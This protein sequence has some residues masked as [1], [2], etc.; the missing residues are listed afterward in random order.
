MSGRASS[1]Q[2]PFASLEAGQGYN[3]LTAGT[4]CKKGISDAIPKKNIYLY[5]DIK[6]AYDPKP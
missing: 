6:T 5:I 4:R 3:F 1:R 2:N